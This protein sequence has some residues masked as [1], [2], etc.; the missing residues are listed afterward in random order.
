M[1]KSWGLVPLPA[2]PRDARVPSA[3]EEAARGG[4]GSRDYG[5]DRR[6]E[7]PDPRVDEVVQKVAAAARHRDRRAGA[8]IRIVGAEPPD[9]GVH[10]RMITVRFSPGHY[11]RGV[12]K[13]YGEL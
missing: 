1:A 11:H 13:K 3:H 6:E 7:P 5:E 4:S 8:H 2:I 12:T 10:G 9:E